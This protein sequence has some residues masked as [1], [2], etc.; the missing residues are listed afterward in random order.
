MR[1]APPFR[2]LLAA[3]ADGGLAVVLAWL[4]APS[5]GRWFAERSIVMLN[6]GDPGTLWVGP[7]PLLL[8]LLGPF[9]YGLPFA[10]ALLLLAEPLFGAGPGHRLLRLEPR[11]ADGA[12]PPAGARW[13]RFLLKS[14]GPWLLT[15]GLVSGFWPLGALAVAAQLAF[16]L[17]GLAA[18]GPARRALHDRWTGTTVVPVAESP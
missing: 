9:V 12:R 5:S 1:P 3:L 2:R 6:I 17:G 11:A 4:L 16:A 13:S 7:L 14:S 8:A 15:L 18:W 10:A